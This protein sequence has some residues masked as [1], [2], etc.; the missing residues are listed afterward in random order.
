MN[1][2][3]LKTPILKPIKF[4]HLLDRPKRNISLNWISQRKWQCSNAM[5]R[6]NKSEGTLSK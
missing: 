6:G 4:A 3:Q 5:T 1:V 2:M